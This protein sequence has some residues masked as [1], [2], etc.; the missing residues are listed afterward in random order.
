MWAYNSFSMISLLTFNPSCGCIRKCVYMC[1]RTILC[2]FMHVGV[3]RWEVDVCASKINFVS[4][5]LAFF[6]KEEI[7]HYKQQPYLD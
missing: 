1:F 2:L 5:T 7:F 6:L 3:S 4:S